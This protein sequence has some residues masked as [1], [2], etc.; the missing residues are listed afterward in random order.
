MKY[1]RNIEIMI[2]INQLKLSVASVLKLHLRIALVLK[3]VHGIMEPF[4]SH[5]C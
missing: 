2:K 4:L 5:S 1:G 3:L